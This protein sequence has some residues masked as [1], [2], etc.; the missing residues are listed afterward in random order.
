MEVEALLQ[1]AGRL[2]G[3]QV[4]AGNKDQ[5]RVETITPDGSARRLYRISGKGIPAVLAV[6]PPVEEVNGK[7]EACSFAAIGAH[8]AKRGVPVPRLFGFDKTSGLLVCEDLGDTRLYEVVNGE[9][10]QEMV[11]LALYEQTVGALANMQVRGAKGFKGSWCWDTVCYDRNLMLERESGYFLQAFCRDYLSYQPPEKPLL[12]DFKQLAREASKAPGSF[13]LHRDFQSRNIMVKEGRVYFIDFQGGRL[14]PL[15]YD[16]ASLL[17]DPYAELDMATQEHLMEVYLS[18]LL[19]LIP[20]DADRF[21]HE[22]VFLAL[23]RNLQILGAFAF[24]GTVRDKPF[25]IQFIGPA[26]R[27]LLELL[28]KPEAAG[29]A[30]LREVA[31]QCSDKVA[32]R[33]HV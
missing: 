7:A 27:S 11:Q 10:S 23:Q 18:S 13:F 12:K 32:R 30:A 2:A 28:A 16:L 15:A 20:Y 17:I 1:E 24:L 14:G 6:A 29:Y 26:L 33:L 4:T 8:L 25:F 5:M 9:G 21:R 31:A 22:Y 3:W 19:E